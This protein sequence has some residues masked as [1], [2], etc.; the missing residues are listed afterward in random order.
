MEEKEKN[1][2][3]NEGT[4]IVSCMCSYVYNSALVISH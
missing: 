1:L 2:E 3:V 4:E